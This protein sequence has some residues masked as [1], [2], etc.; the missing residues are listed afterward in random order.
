NLLFSLQAGA[1][2]DR[3]GFRR[4]TMIA[5]DLGRAALLVTIPVAY[6]FDALTLTQLYVIAFLAGALSVFFFVSYNTL[7]VS[8]V[9]RESYVEANSLLAGSRA[10]SFVAGPSVGGVVVQILSAPYALAADAVSFIVS[11]YYLGSIRP[12]EPPTEDS[13]NGRATAG[14]RVSWGA[15]PLLAWL[16]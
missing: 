16:A 12:E 5:A 4:Q 8:M 9:R 1:L 10:F 3:R 2:V 6:A 7:F 13:A 11:A 14:V 15:P